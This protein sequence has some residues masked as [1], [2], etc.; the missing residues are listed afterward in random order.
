MELIG[1][2]ILQE[3]QA[4]GEKNK[5]EIWK[6]MKYML[7]FVGKNRHGESDKIILARVNFD[8]L[9]YEEIGIVEGLKYDKV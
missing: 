1:I 5:D 8:V 6:G 2:D 9:Y 4:I 3:E 7:I